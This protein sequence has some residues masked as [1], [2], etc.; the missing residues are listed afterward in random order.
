M[1]GEETGGIS[2]VNEQVASSV[3]N[4]QKAQNDI[5]QYFDATCWRRKK[6]TQKWS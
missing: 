6:I 3:Y 2:E 1:N 4:N 5:I